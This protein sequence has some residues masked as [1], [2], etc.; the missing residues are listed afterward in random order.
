MYFQ[1]FT[2]TH[3]LQH[4]HIS[5]NVLMW[6]L[7]GLWVAWFEGGQKREE[8]NYKDGKKVSS[9]FVPKLIVKVKFLFPRN[10]KNKTSNDYKTLEIL[11]D[12]R[13]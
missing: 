1:A 2:L 5:L 10:K 12:S 3:L 9:M 6:K 7:D 13:S 8:S 4:L 11:P